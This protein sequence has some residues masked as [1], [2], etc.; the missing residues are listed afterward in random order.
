MSRK[1]RSIN[2]TKEGPNKSMWSCLEKKASCFVFP[3]KPQDLPQLPTAAPTLIEC[4]S[5]LHGQHDALIIRIHSIF[6]TAFHRFVS[7]YPFS[8]VIHYIQ[9]CTIIQRCVTNNNLTS[10]NTKQY[11]KRS[12]TGTPSNYSGTH[13][14]H[15]CTII[16]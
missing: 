4:L 14:S 13:P 15:H 5:C 12:P 11:T 16:Y 9:N 2:S 10:R 3:A 1:S 7:P 6:I 8:L